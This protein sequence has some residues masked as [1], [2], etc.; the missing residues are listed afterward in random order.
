LI[1]PA[2]LARDLKFKQEAQMMYLA[3]FPPEED[4]IVAQRFCMML[5][6]VYVAPYVIFAVTL[7]IALCILPTLLF[8]VISAAVQ[9]LLQVV[10]YTHM[11][12]D[13]NI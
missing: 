10:Y 9:L 4:K 12:L 8:S 3:R 5:G 7:V 1:D 11:S 13:N 6:F 2:D